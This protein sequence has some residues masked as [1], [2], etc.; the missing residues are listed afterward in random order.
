MSTKYFGDWVEHA[1]MVAAFE[2]SIWDATQSKYVRG[3]AVT[4]M[5]TDDEVLFAAYDGSG[6]DGTALIVF[7]RD[8]KLYEVSASHC[9]CNGLEGEWSPTEING[10]YLL[11]RELYGF[12]DPIKRAFRKLAVSLSGMFTVTDPDGSSMHWT[13]AQARELV[14][15]VT[16]WLDQTPAQP[17]PD[18]DK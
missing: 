11:K 2:D 4:D 9:S 17:T 8:G 1:D 16:A 5:A 14:A 6:Y 12:G 3:N 15:A 13:P 10:P 18:G 7:R